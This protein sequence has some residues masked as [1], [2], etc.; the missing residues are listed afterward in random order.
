M[1][2]FWQPYPF[3]GGLSGICLRNVSR[4]RLAPSRVPLSLNSRGAV[5]KRETAVEVQELKMSEFILLDE[6]LPRA[7]LL[8]DS[9]NER[10]HYIVTRAGSVTMKDKTI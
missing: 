4:A 5:L 2:W 6:D 1:L 10:Y 8:P 7:P 3:I 9:R